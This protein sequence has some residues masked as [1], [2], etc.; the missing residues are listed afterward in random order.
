MDF[1]VSKMDSKFS[2]LFVLLQLCGLYDSDLHSWGKFTLLVQI[3][4][5]FRITSTVMPKAMFYHPS[6]N[7]FIPGNLKHT[8]NYH[9]DISFI[10]GILVYLK[11]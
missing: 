6:E 3:L 10:L 4:S 2:V 9:T 5:S 11:D 8:I 1:S 7:Y